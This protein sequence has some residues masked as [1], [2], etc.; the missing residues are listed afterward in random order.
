MVKF[1][2][3][4]KI[5][6][7][8]G[9]TAPTNVMC[10]GAFT[11]SWLKDAQLTRLDLANSYLLATICV[12]FVLQGQKYF[13]KLINLKTCFKYLGISCIILSLSN[14]LSML[15]LFFFFFFVQWLGQGLIVE[16]CR[17]L[18][19]NTAQ[20][21]SLAAGFLEAW[22]TFLVYVIP[23]GFLYILKGHTW[24]FSLIS[25]GIIYITISFV[26]KQKSSAIPPINKL[27]GKIWTH[28]GFLI[29]N[30][31]IYL[32][33]LLTSGFFFH[34]E[35]FIE[36]YQLST[37]QLEICILPQILASIALQIVLGFFV[38]NNPKRLMGIFSL[39]F[40]SQVIWFVNLLFVRGHLFCLLYVLTG[41]IGWGCFG[42]LVNIAWKFLFNK[43]CT[44]TEACLRNSVNFGFLANAAGPLV[45]ILILK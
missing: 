26:L 20:H 28:K 24:Q 34:L 12:F 30:I 7:L 42:L 25:L 31:I 21:Y 32:P 11:E 3:L 19:S 38:K 15:S 2:N 4:L 9:L 45:F 43:D 17:V 6:L 40:I 39:L 18:L 14:F 41:A 36:H 8:Y 27:F 35:A 23:F 10:L 5:F 1:F 29:A 37:Q 22:G 13:E 16:E 33:V 44:W